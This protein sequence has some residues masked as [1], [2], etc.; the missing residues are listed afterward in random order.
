MA[1]FLIFFGSLGA[2]AL[3]IAIV[4]FFIIKSPFKFP[5][6]TISFDVS[7]KHSPNINDEIDKFFIQNGFEQILIHQRKIDEWKK[8]CHKRIQK[9]CIRKIRTKQ[10]NR[11]LDE[12]HAY[13]FNLIRRR[14]RYKQSNYIKTSY[15]ALVVEASFK[16]DFATLK[17]RYQALASINFATTLSAYNSANQR[18]LM[19]KELREKIMKRD[20]YT[21]RKCG[22][23]MPDG[24][25]LQ[26][27]HITPISKG[28]KTIE[29]NL[30]V[31]C[32]KCNGK[33]SNKLM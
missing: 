25:G 14:T 20:N 11:S 23:Y 32:S 29:A 31:L 26:V 12:K 27:D 24:V 4:Y 22:K 9:S 30:Q 6:F 16:T 15:M 33:K 3:C 5:Y 18:K 8:D 13:E 19:T 2:V 21:C 17:S 28:G 1:F 7:G 10:Y